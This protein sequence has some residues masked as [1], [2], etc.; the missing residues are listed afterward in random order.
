MTET[1]TGILEVNED[2]EIP[3]TSAGRGCSRG[4]KAHFREPPGINHPAE[5]LMP[6]PR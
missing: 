1:C 5:M 3:D 2:G 4:A 6:E